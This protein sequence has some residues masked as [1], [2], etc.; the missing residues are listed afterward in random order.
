MNLVYQ[1]QQKL[2]NENQ[3]I[4]EN[5]NIWFGCVFGGLSLRNHMVCKSKTMLR[6][7]IFIRQTITQIQ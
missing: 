2:E 6:G 1:Q 5:K 4:L 7:D 3:M